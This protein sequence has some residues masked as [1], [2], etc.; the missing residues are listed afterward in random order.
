MNDLSKWRQS[1]PPPKYRRHRAGVRHPYMSQAEAAKYFG[2]S[3]STFRAW[4]RGMR[5][6]PPHVQQEVKP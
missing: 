3:V 6:L 2:V 1:Q 5:P 4:E